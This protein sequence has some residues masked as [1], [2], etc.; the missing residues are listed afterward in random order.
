MTSRGGW[1]LVGVGAGGRQIWF[2]P[3][4]GVVLHTRA[5]VSRPPERVRVPVLLRLP[6]GRQRERR[7]R[8]AAR[9][10]V[11]ASRAGPDD[12]GEPGEPT[13]DHPGRWS[14]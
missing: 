14:A 13:A 8:S 6:R 7:P 5:Q 4:S 1:A 11:Q 10:R 9:R 2:C 12:P 3:S